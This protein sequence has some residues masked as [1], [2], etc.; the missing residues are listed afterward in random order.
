METRQL[1]LLIL[2]GVHLVAFVVLLI[3]QRRP[4]LLLPISVFTLLCLTQIF[5]KSEITLA[6]PLA[7][8]TSLARALR[9]AAIVLAVPSI[10]L[11]ARR[12]VLRV[13]AR[14]AEALTASS[15]ER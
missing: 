5:W 6:L 2:F 4:S 3:K 11:M 10:A 15:E 7:G 1:L 8:P 13:Q 14:K 12:I 9:V